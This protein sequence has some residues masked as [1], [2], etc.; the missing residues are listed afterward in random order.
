MNNEKIVGN[1]DFALQQLI[2]R[3]TRAKGTPGLARFAEDI[4]LEWDNNRGTDWY[5]NTKLVEEWENRE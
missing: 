5:T 1:F 2:S 3:L 4:L